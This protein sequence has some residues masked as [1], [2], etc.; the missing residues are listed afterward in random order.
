MRLKQKKILQTF[1]S[2][3]GLTLDEAGQV[4]NVQVHQTLVFVW[5]TKEKMEN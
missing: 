2:L 3:V 1:N 4:D 5:L